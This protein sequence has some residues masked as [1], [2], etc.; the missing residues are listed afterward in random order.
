MAFLQNIKPSSGD[1]ISL[2]ETAEQVEA[3]ALCVAALCDEN[4]NRFVSND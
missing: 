2:V 1:A 3:V 4:H